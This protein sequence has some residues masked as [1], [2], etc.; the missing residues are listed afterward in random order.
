MKRYAR[1][2]SNWI[3]IPNTQNTNPQ[4]T[5]QS[6]AIVSLTQDEVNRRNEIFIQKLTESL[7]ELHDLPDMQGIEPIPDRIKDKAKFFQGFA[8]FLLNLHTYKD[9]EFDGDEKANHLFGDGTEVED[10]KLTSNQKDMYLKYLND[11]SGDSMEADYIKQAVRQANQEI[12]KE[13]TKAASKSSLRS[14]LGSTKIPPSAEPKALGIRGALQEQD[15]HDRIPV[16]IEQWQVAPKQQDVFT[17]MS[18]AGLQEFAK[19]YNE[20]LIVESKLEEAALDYYKGKFKGTLKQEM[21][22]EAPQDIQNEEQKVN[23]FLED[24][25]TIAYLKTKYTDQFS[26]A[27]AIEQHGISEETL[28]ASTVCLAV[29]SS[30]DLVTMKATSDAIRCLDQNGNFDQSKYSVLQGYAQEAITN[31]I[32]NSEGIITHGEFIQENALTPALLYNF[33][34]I[35]SKRPQNRPLNSPQDHKILNC[36]MN[37]GGTTLTSTGTTLESELQAFANDPN[38]QHIYIPI[39]H[40]QGHWT[41]LVGSKTRGGNKIEFISID[42]YYEGE[43]RKVDKLRPYLQNLNMRYTIRH[44]T[45]DERNNT[46]KIPYQHDGNSCGAYT[47]WALSQMRRHHLGVTKEKIPAG[48]EPS[49]YT[50]KKLTSNHKDGEGMIMRGAVQSGF[51]NGMTALRQRIEQQKNRATNSRPNANT[52]RTI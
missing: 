30:N 32:N 48:I 25:G 19:S 6:Q 31:Q 51:A 11:I 10:Y 36:M 28:F 35:E 52:G 47:I 37:Q 44:L 3:E 42:P 50:D 9:Y 45:Q 4:P 15:A 14:A 5:S 34:E 12:E 39:S 27:R 26:L 38:Q 2:G 29:V 21:I 49:I 24:L 40:N 17:F 41:S 43:G 33:N 1:V 8:K 18:P 22:A 7:S 13:R 20:N 46:Y 16:E 23:K